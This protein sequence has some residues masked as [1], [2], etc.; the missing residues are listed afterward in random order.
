MG[1]GTCGKNEKTGEMMGYCY[2][3]ICNDSDCKEEIH[4]GL[5][6]VCGGMHRGG[7]WGCGY[8]FCGDHLHHLGFENKGLEEY[9]T[10]GSEY[11]CYDR[12]VCKNCYNDMIKCIRDCLEWDDY[13]IEVMDELE[14][15]EYLK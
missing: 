14:E 5:S 15:L 11:N 13:S 10:G 7:E 2:E 9:L 1:W 8:Y 4:H 6:Y 12:Q 3:G